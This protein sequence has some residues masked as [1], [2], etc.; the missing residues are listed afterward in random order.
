[1][2]CQTDGLHAAHHQMGQQSPKFW[3]R[4]EHS[5]WP[6]DLLIHTG[7]AD[8]PTATSASR[9]CHC[10]A[11]VSPPTWTLWGWASAEPCT[12]QKTRLRIKKMEDL[13]K[14]DA[15]TSESLQKCPQWSPMSGV[16][17]AVE[18]SSSVMLTL[19]TVYP[20]RMLTLNTILVL[21]SRG[22]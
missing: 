13:V 9:L 1:M 5:L 6:P 8:R 21:L 20:S 14:I 2:F 10:D 15:T 7:R 18:G 4:S 22:R 12:L 19:N 3:W 16:L 17:T 11:E